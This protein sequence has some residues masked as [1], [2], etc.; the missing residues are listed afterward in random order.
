MHVNLHL[1]PSH[2]LVVSTT[3]HSLPD[4]IAEDPLVVSVKKGQIPPRQMPESSKHYKQL[5]KAY[6]DE[7]K[8]AAQPNPTQPQP[9]PCTYTRWHPCL[10]LPHSSQVSNLRK[11][12]MEEWQVRE[13]IEAI[14][15]E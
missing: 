10:G 14:V 5:R 13:R 7:V 8:Q 3:Q 2:F 11:K 12:F 9:P 4:R 1:T 15:V 6:N